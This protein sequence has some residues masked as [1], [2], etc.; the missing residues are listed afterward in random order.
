MI[1]LVNERNDG[2]TRARRIN[3]MHIDLVAQ[4][5]KET[6]QSFYGYRV[7]TIE[8]TFRLLEKSGFEHEQLIF[9]HGGSLG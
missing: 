5:R 1:V 4:L 8:W 2:R 3:V 7:A 6:L 9:L